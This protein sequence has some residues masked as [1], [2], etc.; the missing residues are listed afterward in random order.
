MKISITII[1][2][3]LFP[4]FLSAQYDSRKFTYNEGNDKNYINYEQLEELTTKMIENNPNYYNEEDVQKFIHIDLSTLPNYTDEELH[5]RLLAIPTTIPLKFTPQIGELIRYFV[6][7]RREY[8]TRMLTMSNVYF[9][10]YEE[11]FDEADIPLELKCLSIVESALNPLAKSRVGATGLWQFMHGTARHEG[12]EIN[13]LYDA[14]SDVYVSTEHA[15]KFLKKLHNLYGDWFLALAAYNAGPGNVNKA[16][17]YS[18]G[19]DFW[20]V[21]HRLPRETQNYVPSFIAMVYIMHYHKD[22][23]LYPGKPKIDFKNTVIEIVKEKQ[24]TKYIAEL[25]GTS[26][27]VI[28]QY[29]PCLKK[30]IIPKVENGYRL[31]LPKQYAYALNEKKNLLAIDPYIFN[32][33]FEAP[34]NSIANGIDTTVLDPQKQAEVARNIEVEKV[35]ELTQEV[36]KEIERKV[37]REARIEEFV[38]NTESDS[39][40]AKTDNQI[41]TFESFENKE[42]KT[43]EV[44]IK[45]DIEVLKTDSFSTEKLDSSLSKTEIALVQETKIDS[46]PIENSSTEMLASQEVQN[47]I[48]D[49]VDVNKA[50]LMAIKKEEEIKQ[51]K[52]YKIVKVEEVH[53][54]TTYHKVSKGE[55]LIEIAK[56]Y[57][58]S[59]NKILEWNPK[60]DKKNLQLG[61]NLKLNLQEKIVK[62]QYESIASSSTQEENQIIHKVKKG[63]NLYQISKLYNVSL[64]DLKLWNN[65][66]DESLKIG[67]EIVIISSGVSKNNISLGDYFY[68]VSSGGDTLQ[69][70]SNLYKVPLE[71]LKKLNN[72]SED[73]PLQA[74]EKI[75]IP[76]L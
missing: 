12:M 65:L 63:E 51:L 39:V 69:S 36:V 71:T 53:S 64:N 20:T 27:D 46:L 11:I 44:A 59:V 19:Y 24:S 2:I 60:V 35:K 70:A 21:K 22:Y 9:P 3:F 31:V 54:K 42:T 6:T 66:E 76:S 57:G 18:G 13:T 50:Y 52:K 56:N 45:A 34:S 49:T 73:E 15:A 61:A 1:F 41:V 4:F 26:E 37:D 29:N 5:K 25:V 14:R 67:K 40:V 48:A 55:S 10:I 8:V 30:G 38:K 33:A 75:K 17:K 47:K 62:P 7:K 28:K 43:N 32:P 58:V 23:F 72:K 68:H 16:I 74:G